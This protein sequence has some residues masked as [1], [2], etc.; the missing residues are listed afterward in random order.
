MPQAPAVTIQNALAVH[1][2][3]SACSP[4]LL[5]TAAQ[6]CSLLT[7]SDGEELKSYDDTPFLCIILKGSA[8]VYTKDRASDLLLRILRGGD[9]FGVATLFGRT[10][11]SAV[12]KIIAAEA[13]EALCMSED[14]VRHLI[15][16][17]SALAMRYIDFLADRI[18]FLNQ[19][20]ACLGAG[21][22]EEKLCAW[23]DAQLSHDGGDTYLL[24]MSMTRL[25][26]TLGVG[27]ASL[28]RALDELEARGLIKRE[29]KSL[30]VPC[31]AALRGY[32]KS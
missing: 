10:G 9:T 15:M 22:A 14:T 7:F 4:A 19:R 29:G 21:S 28:Y 11:G 2:L 16:S 6:G 31:R 25:A 20:I 23:L 27:R 8:L 26:D 1:P 5:E 30:H 3:F 17:D 12:T 24:P 18:R 13:T 32:G